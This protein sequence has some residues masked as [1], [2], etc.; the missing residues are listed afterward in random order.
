ML[1]I[2]SLKI[3][4]VND[5]GKVLSRNSRHR[6]RSQDTDD[7]TC[8]TPTRNGTPASVRSLRKRLSLYKFH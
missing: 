4:Q 5:D 8:G 1:L 6:T 3:K 7:P 2:Q